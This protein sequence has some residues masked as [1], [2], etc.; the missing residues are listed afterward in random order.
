VHDNAVN[1]PTEKNSW[2]F[3]YYLNNAKYRRFDVHDRLGP[4]FKSE[5]EPALRKIRGDTKQ[6]STPIESRAVWDE[7][8]KVFDQMV[9]HLR[10]QLGVS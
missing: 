10:S 9:E 4:P 6:P 7:V 2:S 3:G 8:H 5:L 1:Y